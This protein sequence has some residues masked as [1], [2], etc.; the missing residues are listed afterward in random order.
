MDNLAKVNRN[1]SLP[2]VVH[3]IVQSDENEML[4]LDAG[5]ADLIVGDCAPFISV[6]LNSTLYE[7]KLKI[8][9]ED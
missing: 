2:N 3:D 9:D 8:D 7:R 1:V 5:R 6:Q 4:E